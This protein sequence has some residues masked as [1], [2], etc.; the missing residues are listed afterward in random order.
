MLDRRPTTGWRRQKNA[1]KPR[2]ARWSV[3][4]PGKPP[5]SRA[6]SCRALVGDPTP[7]WLLRFGRTCRCIRCP[8][9]RRSRH[10]FPPLARRFAPAFPLSSR[11]RPLPDGS[12]RQ[13]SAPVR[14]A[15][16][17]PVFVHLV[18]LR[19]LAPDSMKFAVERSSPLRPGTGLE[20]REDVLQA[21]AELFTEFG[22]AATSIDAVA[23]RL[24]ATKGRIY[25]YY[26]SKADLFF[27][28]QIAAMRLIADQVCP[29]A[30]G[31]ADPAHR[32]LA[33]AFRHARVLLHDM[34]M[35]KVAVQGLERH[36]FGTAT[37][38]HATV[39]RTIIAMRDTYEQM[40]A[41]VIAAGIE[42]G[43]FVPVSRRLST[44][45][46]FG[47]LNWATIWYRPKPGQTDDDVDAVAWELARGA[48]RS[49]LSVQGARRLRN[50][51]DGARPADR[52]VGIGP[53]AET[54]A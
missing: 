29:L 42:A 33:M 6:V 21:A 31:D 47:V 23:D 2:L 44:K 27:D 11:P 40:F 54:T 4:A 20:G 39:L 5:S 1:A 52:F 36:L 16:G 10:R 18:R 8:A 3:A 45:P 15:P 37:T 19:R 30:D 41:N 38:R 50:R 13:A 35:Q 9:W 48:M 22:Y 51:L 49:V 53:D 14:F 46:F 7:G 24:G 17:P 25:H 28:V 34:T 32:L 43:D 26:R 12:R